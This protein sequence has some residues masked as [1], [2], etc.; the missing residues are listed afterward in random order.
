VRQPLQPFGRAL[1]I[2]APEIAGSRRRAVRRV[3]DADAFGQQLELLGRL[4]QPRREAR[5]IQEP[6]E[7]VARVGEVSLRER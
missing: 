6:P 1:E 5:R 7:V 3:R 2:G 4:I